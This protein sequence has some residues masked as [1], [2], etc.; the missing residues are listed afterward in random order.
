MGNIPTQMVIITTQLN[1]VFP[2]IILEKKIYTIRTL[3]SL[4]TVPSVS[5]KTYLHTM[6]RWQVQYRSVHSLCKMAGQCQKFI[7]FILEAF[8]PFGSLEF[9][10]LTIISVSPIYIYMPLSHFYEVVTKF[11]KLWLSI[12][13]ERI[14][15]W[16]NGPQIRTWVAYVE[17]GNWNTEAP[18]LCTRI[19]CEMLTISTRIIK[20]MGWYKLEKMEERK[21]IP[22]LGNFYFFP[23]SYPVLTAN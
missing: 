14:H 16:L 18:D 17:A 10:L 3:Q 11:K 12:R 13:W 1:K 23:F 22:T 15:V 19:F 8:W 6:A 21:R 4:S 5:G 20:G 7:S 2:I 9:L